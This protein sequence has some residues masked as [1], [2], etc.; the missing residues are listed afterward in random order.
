[1]G[2]YY[3]ISTHYN[4]KEQTMV[5][6]DADRDLLWNEIGKLVEQNKTLKALVERQERCIDMYIRYVDLLTQSAK[7]GK[8]GTD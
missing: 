2:V 3:R 5:K 1:M 4:T 8:E 7:I 6:Y